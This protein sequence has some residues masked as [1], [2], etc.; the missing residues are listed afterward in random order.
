MLS[1]GLANDQ[2][3]CEFVAGFLQ[4]GASACNTVEAALSAAYIALHDFAVYVMFPPLDLSG[5]C[6]SGKQLRIMLSGYAP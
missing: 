5:S 4:A 1:V 3:V 6:A 2:L